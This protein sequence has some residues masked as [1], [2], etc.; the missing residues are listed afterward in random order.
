[1]SSISAKFLAFPGFPSIN[2]GFSSFSQSEDDTG[3]ITKIHK[4][5]GSFLFPPPDDF[6]AILTV[7]LFG[8]SILPPFH[9]LD[10]KIRMTPTIASYTLPFCDCS[11]FLWLTDRTEPIGNTPIW[12]PMVLQVCQDCTRNKQ[13]AIAPCSRWQASC[14]A[15]PWGASVREWM[16]ARVTWAK[17]LWDGGWVALRGHGKKTES[18]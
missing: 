18:E 3:K 4:E 5:C 14:L 2:P 13:L 6:E 10:R 11:L 16:L 7:Q 12:N 17:A 8:F 9:S 15:D 1:M